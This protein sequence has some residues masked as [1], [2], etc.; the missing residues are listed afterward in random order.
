MFRFNLIKLILLLS[1]TISAEALAAIQGD[2]KMILDQQGKPIPFALVKVDQQK[3]MP[4]DQSGQI[5]TTVSGDQVIIFA[6]GYETIKLSWEEWVALD[7]IILEEKTENL[8][9]VVVSATRTERSVEDLPM[10]VTVLNSQKIQETGGMRLSEILREQTGLQ[11]ASDHGAGLQMQGLDSDY[12]LILLDGEPL[13][14]RTAG[15]FDLDRISVSN[16]ERIEILRGPS[17]AIYGSEAMAGVVNIITKNNKEQSQATVA[18][19]HRSF[20]SWNPSLE[21]GI[22]QKNWSSDIFIDHFR[23]DGFDLT[24]ETVGQTQNPY[25]A[26]TGQLKIRGKISPKLDLSLFGRGYLENSTGQ[27]QIGRDENTELLDLSNNREDFNFNPTLRFKPHENWLFTLRGMSSWFTTQSSSR[28][29]SDGLLFD[30]QDFSQF[31]HRTEFQTDYQIR[32]NQLL[33]L[34]LGQ[35]VETVEATRYE[36]KNRFDAGYLFLQHQWDPGQKINI[37]SGLR[38]DL[39]SQYGKRLSPKISGQYRISDKFS[40]QA[41][42]GAGFKAPDF[43]Q[44]LLNFNNAASG[45]YVFGANLAEEGIARLEEQGLVAQILFAPENLGQL[46][47]ETSWALNS[48]FRWQI[49]EK[50]SLQLNAFRNTIDNLIEAAPIAQLVTGQNAFSYFN[51]RSVVTQGIELDASFQLAPKVS[52]SAGYAFLDT[53]DQEVL[54]GIDSGEFFKRNSQNQTQRV[55]RS[56]YGGLFNRSRHSG[57]FKINYQENLTGTNWAL[58]AI[59]RGKFGF[60]DRNGNLILDDKGEYADGWVSLNLTVS[61]TLGKGIFIEAGGT[62]LL[63]TAT[64]AQPNNPGRVLFVGMKVPL[65][66]ANN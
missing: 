38:A 12:I 10:P 16:I 64:P 58:R 55:V 20:N 62:N 26:T 8:D 41:S 30:Q 56:D 39:H 23:T 29:Q 61:K 5:Q 21:A 48:G 15:T 34:G 51:I 3:P 32:P 24:P 18:L 9:Q 4:V 36:D 22:T 50:T 1:F 45:Y 2:E 46:Q 27:L 44:L 6:M 25:Q 49:Q 59:Y 17:S 37:V 11:I 33:T 63:N 13:I 14:G 60:A 28:Y 52:L 7:E 47:A 43:R 65:I 35:L 19:R 42:I 54:E 31:Y 40:W 57:N 53:R 66:H